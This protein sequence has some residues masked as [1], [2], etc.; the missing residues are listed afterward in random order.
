MSQPLFTVVK[1]T[2]TEA[3]LAALTQVLTDLQQAAKSRTSG[4]YRNLWGRPTP[5]DHGPV[6]FNPSA[7]NSQTLF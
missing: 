6:V 1:G 5:R 3:E 2:P 4:G 7:F